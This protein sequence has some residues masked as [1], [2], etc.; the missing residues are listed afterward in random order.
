MASVGARLTGRIL[1]ELSLHGKTDLPGGRDV[2]AL[3]VLER[4]WQARLSALPSAG[5]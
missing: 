1:A 4:N 5:R 2:A 3:F